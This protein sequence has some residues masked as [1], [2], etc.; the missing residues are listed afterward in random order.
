[1]EHL[2]VNQ[3]L[4]IILESVAVLDIETIKL[5]HSL[6]RV[7][8]ESILANRDLP[9]YDVSAMDG[10]AV[11]GEDVAS[12]PVLLEIIEDIK[13][14]DIPTATVQRGQCARIMTGA[15]GSGGGEC[16]DPR[17]RYPGNF[18]Q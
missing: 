11:R 6:G 4:R 2:Q 16:S 12:V 8:A 13:A 3:A 10:F 7:L 15:T 18:G 17:R 5:E 1:M 14:G 9:P